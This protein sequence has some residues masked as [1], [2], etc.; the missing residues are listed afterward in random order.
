MV[1]IYRE[2]G[3]KDRKDYLNSLAQEHNIE[4][5]IVIELA[6]I[7]GENEDF[8]G[9]PIQLSNIENDYNPYDEDDYM[10]DDFYERC[11]K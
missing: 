1:N 7:L 2:N 10:D 11:L 8:D 4:L 6:N 9:L 3:Y 5:G